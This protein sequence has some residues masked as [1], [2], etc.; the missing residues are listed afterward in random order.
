MSAEELKAAIREYADEHC[1]GWVHAH[2]VIHLGDLDE[3]KPHERLLILNPAG[4]GEGP[5]EPRLLRSTP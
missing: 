5:G 4:S 2:A 3:A 1:P